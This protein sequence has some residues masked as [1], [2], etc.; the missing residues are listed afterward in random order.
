MT[1]DKS[2]IG[3]PFFEVALYKYYHIGIL[4]LGVGSLSQSHSP[5]SHTGHNISSDSK[6][7]YYQPLLAPRN[8]KLRENDFLFYISTE[9]D[10]TFNDMD[11]D[12][13]EAL[14][15]KIVP[16]AMQYTDADGLNF[17]ANPLLSM[18]NPSVFPNAVPARLLCTAARFRNPR[19]LTTSLVQCNRTRLSLE[20]DKFTWCRRTCTATL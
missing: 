3:N 10:Y 15:T 16:R 1:C 8:Y 9:D 18:P 5:L 4:I 11:D 13:R 17:G 12:N 6:P 7:R 20:G 19:L 14:R 2:N